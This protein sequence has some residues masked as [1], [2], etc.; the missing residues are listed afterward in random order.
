VTWFHCVL[1]LWSVFLLVWLAAALHPG[2][3]V[4]RETQASRL[5]HALPLTA[6]VALFVPAVSR[7]LPRLSMRVVPGGLAGIGFAIAAMGI[8]CAIVSRLVLGRFWSNT[9]S[10]KHDHRLVQAGPFAWVRHPIYTGVVL[11]GVG[12]AMALGTLAG[13]L[14]LAIGTAAV[15]RKMGIEER[16]LGEHFGDAHALYRER[17][18]RLIPYIW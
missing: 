15:L 12:T 16:L 8:A 2:K 6:A 14:G 3:S 4:Y 1:A 5:S 13:L 7:N 9:V 11:A 10:L 18:K 17:V